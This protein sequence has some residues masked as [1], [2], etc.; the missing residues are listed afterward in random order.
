MLK[1]D[2]AKYMWKMLLANKNSDLKITYSDIISDDYSG[3]A[4]WIAEY[5]FGPEKRK[6]T[7]HVRAVFAF[8]DEKIIHHK[9]NFN[10]WSWS[11]QAL[12]LTGLL[13]GWTSFLKNK[14]RTKVNKSLDKFIS[15]NKSGIN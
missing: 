9:D 5:V 10:L 14:I 11:R 15:A 7:N 4:K 1:G 3:E 13:M 12:G 2:K 8:K 6:I